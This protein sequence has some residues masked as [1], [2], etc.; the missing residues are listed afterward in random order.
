MVNSTMV[1]FMDPLGYRTLKNAGNASLFFAR[2]CRSLVALT[3]LVDFLVFRVSGLV[4]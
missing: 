1:V 4:T 2:R 3:R